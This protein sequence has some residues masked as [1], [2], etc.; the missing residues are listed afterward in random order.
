MSQRKESI[1]IGDYTIDELVPRRKRRKRM[2]P[3]SVNI[4]RPSSDQL[5]VAF[6]TIDASK[7]I[8]MIEPFLPYQQRVRNNIHPGGRK[9]TMTTRAI[10]VAMLTLA[11]MGEK[12]SI[13]RV[14]RLLDEGIDAGTRL[15]LGLDP[16]AEIT[17]RV[18]SRFYNQITAVFDPSPH[19]H[20]NQW[21]K[22]PQQIKKFLGLEPGTKLTAKERDS[23][24]KKYLKENE[25]RLEEII[26]RGL[27]ATHPEDIVHTGDYAIDESYIPSW[28]NYGNAN[29]KST[30]KD[31]NGK[32][33]KNIIDPQEYVDPD[34]Q[35][36]SKFKDHSDPL[37]PATRPVIGKKEFG[38]GYSFAA[39]VRIRTEGSTED[40]DMT[41]MLYEH[42]SVRGAKSNTAKEGA[43]L[44]QKMVEYHQREDDAQGAPDRIRRDI[45]A[46]REYSISKEWQ[47]RMH[48]LGFNPHFDLTLPQR[49]KNRTL[50]CG[51]L[52]LEGIPYSPSLPMELRT[53]PKRPTFET[54]QHKAA[55]A[56]YYAER[57]K[58]RIRVE[59]ISRR[60]DGSLKVYCAASNLA[61]CTVACAN[62]PIS[63]EGRANRLE[64]GSNSQVFLLPT[65][66][67][68]CTK[69]SVTLTFDEVPY[70]QVYVPG[71]PQHLV[72]Y[73]RRSCMEG[74]MGRIKDPNGQS[75]RRGQIFTMGLAKMTLA[76]L[77]NAM[78]VNLAEMTRWRARIEVEA[79]GVKHVIK[80]RTPRAHTRARRLSSP[81]KNEKQIKAALK[82]EFAA[83][84]WKLDTT[85]GEIRPK[86]KRLVSV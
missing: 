33:V 12:M 85:T 44:M 67:E 38:L 81:L 83:E 5:T 37:N 54:L 71:S 15:N 21:L 80:P 69:S 62:K 59:R 41:P 6:Q 11:I 20:S 55:K 34:A 53:P 19:A 14:Q 68:I 29:R 82:K 31:G 25:D 28:E 56:L 70:W 30:K 64:I 9:P 78:A 49:E 72:S 75:V 63:L 13:S 40:D 8:D 18:V 39:L 23:F 42:T 51:I 10:L 48:E 17:G 77:V 84:G 52:V 24:K 4:P 45:L 36:W 60:A 61:A 16:K 26:H 57:E 32:L 22:D 79:A 86:K 35:M 65:K 58:Y 46:D 47:R 2:E 43:R 1:K 66:P 27:L 74:A 76:I 3:L 7:I 50:A 73:G